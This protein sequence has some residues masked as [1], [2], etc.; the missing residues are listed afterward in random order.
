MNKIFNIWMQPVYARFNIENTKW[1]W[2]ILA[3]FPISSQLVALL[4]EL[5]KADRF[6]WQTF[7]GALGLSLLILLVL[8]SYVWFVMLVQNIGIQF[9]PANANLIPRLRS[10]LQI[11]IALPI[12]VFA[13]CGMLASWIV[14]KQFSMLPAFVCVIVSVFF[15]LIVRTQWAVIPM[16]MCFQ[17]PTLLVRSG[18]K[19]LDK[20]LEQIFH[21][22]IDLLLL[23]FSVLIVIFSLR[24]IFVVRDAKLYKMYQRTVAFRHGLAG[25]RVSETSGMRMF[26][27]PYLWW[28]KQ[29]VRRVFTQKDGADQSHFGASAMKL[30][31]FVLGPRLHW[32]TISAQLIAMIVTGLFAMYLMRVFSSESSVDFMTG[33]GLGFGAIVLILQCLLFSMQLP[34]VLYQTRIEQGLISLTPAVTDLRRF[35]RLLRTFLLRQFL[36][37]FGI[38]C[39]TSA[40]LIGRG[41]G[42]SL[43]SAIVILLLSAIF[44]MIMGIARNHSKMR[45]A[46]DHPLLVIILTSLGIFGLCACSLFLLPLSMALFYAGLI[47]LVTT[48][49]FV[50]R[51]RT[52]DLHPGFPIG[53]SV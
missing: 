34:H 31:A 23:L 32:T 39:L 8:L 47:V 41:T 5:P 52:F 18:V 30:S 20:Q 16:V 4:I 51:L 10:T 48:Y 38:S 45:S 22:P 26:S 17:V 1:L 33:F 27:N 24:W 3:F 50:R 46:N 21:L 29:R 42:L 12:I 13:F 35:D 25:G 14:T 19:D 7:A 49:Y 53:R 28:M 15:L 2:L 44:P 43:R 37:L 40:F 6:H 11:A 36:V 9:S